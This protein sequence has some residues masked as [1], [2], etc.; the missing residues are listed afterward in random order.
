MQMCIRD[1]DGTV[2]SGALSPDKD[3]SI[4]IGDVNHRVVEVESCAVYDGKLYFNANRTLPDGGKDC[5]CVAWTALPPAPVIE[6]PDENPAQDALVDVYKRQPVDE[7]IDAMG[8][9]G[10][11]LPV[12]L[13]ETALGGLAATPTGERVKRDLQGGAQAA[14]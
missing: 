11:R 6:K 9:V 10:R 14:Y 12:E 4:Q 13:K 2:K 1:R 5:D 3:C 7:V 8:E